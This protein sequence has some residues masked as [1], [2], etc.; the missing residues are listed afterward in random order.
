MLAYIAA[1]LLGI[2]DIVSKNSLLSTNE[3]DKSSMLVL[4][5]VSI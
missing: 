2:K 3:L 4:D 1:V 5:M